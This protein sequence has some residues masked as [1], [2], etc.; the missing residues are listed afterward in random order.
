MVFDEVHER[1]LVTDLGLALAIEA[2]SSLRPDL[3]GSGKEGEHVAVVGVERP[4]HS[5]GNLDRSVGAPRPAA[6]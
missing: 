5:G 2:R 3:P 1:H 6:P 4:P